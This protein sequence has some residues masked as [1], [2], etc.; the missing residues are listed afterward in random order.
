LRFAVAL[1]VVPA[2]EDMLFR[3]LA[4]FSKLYSRM[5]YNENKE[6]RRYV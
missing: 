4:N 5:L 6:P 1:N 3:I 2:K